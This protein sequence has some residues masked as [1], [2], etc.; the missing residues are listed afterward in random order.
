MTAKSLQVG[1]LLLKSY[2]LL[3][4][5]GPLDGLAMMTPTYLQDVMAPASLLTKAIPID[6]HYISHSL[7]PV[8]A[9][10]GPLQQPT[11]TYATCPPLNFLFIPGS[12]PD[13]KV[14]SELIRF[15]Q[16][17]VEEVDIVM[18][19]CTGSILLASAGVLNGR[20]ASTNKNVQQFAVQTFPQ[21]QWTE[22]GRW[23]VDGKFW[24]SSGVTAGM[25]MMAAFLMSNYDR[26]LVKFTHKIAE[27]IPKEQDDD[28]FT[29]ILDE[30]NQ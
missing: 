17:R 9:T 30:S 28:P 14:S 11:C 12:P 26:E 19:V 6:F 16:Q 4:A 8:A 24:T 10:A 27:F 2:Q 25:D 21:V 13:S 18:S 3:D 5:S 23:T 15:V 29:W 22:K 1:V 7:D 20:K